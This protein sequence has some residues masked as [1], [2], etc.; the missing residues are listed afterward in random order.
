MS[1]RNDAIADVVPDIILFR[2]QVAR[3]DVIEN[4]L[5]CATT[6]WSSY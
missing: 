4:V 6:D 3:Q 2:Q 1:V 5:T